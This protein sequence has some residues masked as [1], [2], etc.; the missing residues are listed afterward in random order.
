[1]TKDYNKI[2]KFK[3]LIEKVKWKRFESWAGCEPD[4]ID[5]Y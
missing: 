5:N 2:L 4:I 1:M 3:K